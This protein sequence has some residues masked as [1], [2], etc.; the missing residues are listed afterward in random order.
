MAKKDLDIDEE[1]KRL[2]RNI[3]IDIMRSE[4]AFDN[5]MEKLDKDIDKAV[6]NKLSDFDEIKDLTSKH[7]TTSYTDSSLERYK[8]KLDK[9]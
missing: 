5:V 6:S 1:I 7:L 8:R 4:H 2:S 9:I 3:D